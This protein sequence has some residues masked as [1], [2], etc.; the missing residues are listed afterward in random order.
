MRRGLSVD[1]CTR[2]AMNRARLE[3]E[4]NQRLKSRLIWQYG[5]EEGE[6]RYRLESEAAARDLLAWQSLPG[7]PLVRS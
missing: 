5:P 4:A 7:A 6:R 1:G 3:D 2:R